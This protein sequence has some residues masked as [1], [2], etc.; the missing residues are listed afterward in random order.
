MNTRPL[1]LSDFHIRVDNLDLE[2][3]LETSATAAATDE[4][5]NVELGDM[6]GNNVGGADET[7]SVISASVTSTA[8]TGAGRKGSVLG[9]IGSTKKNLIPYRFQIALIPR[10]DDGSSGEVL[11]SKMRHREDWVLRCDTEDE[12]HNWV[13]QMRVVSPS[14]FKE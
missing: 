8:A 6:R 13:Q 14:S 5:G 2:Q 3:R 1:S 12:L 7:A 9:G 10:D 11:S 4:D